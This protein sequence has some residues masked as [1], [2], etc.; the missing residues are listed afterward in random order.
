MLIVIDP[1]HGG[2]DPGA[3]GNGLQE[4]DITLK[5]AKLVRDKLSKYEADVQLTRVEDVTVELWE[6]VTAANNAKADFFCS[7]HVNAGGGTGFESYVFPG[8]THSRAYQEIIHRKVMTLLGPLGVAGAT[9]QAEYPAEAIPFKVSI[10]H[11][12]QLPDR[13]QK[14][15]RFYVLRYTKMPAVLLENLFIDNPVDASFLKIPRFLDDLAD[16]IAGGIASALALK[17]KSV[18]DPAGEVRRLKERGLLANYHD[19]GAVVTWGEFAAVLNRILDRE[20]CKCN[21]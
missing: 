2:R 10:D 21:Q 15:A 8:A 9:R 16:V 13:G 7:L 5:L 3:C 20:G 11:L 4:K 14:L 6:R 1:G 12:L 19:P 18:W 17:Q